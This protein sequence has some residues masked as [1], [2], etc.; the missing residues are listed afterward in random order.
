M[1]KELQSKTTRQR[2]TGWA[3][4]VLCGIGWACRGDNLV[5]VSCHAGK[6]P[7]HGADARQGRVPGLSGGGHAAPR[8]S[9]GPIPRGEGTGPL[10]LSA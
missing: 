10:A 2:L 4:W 6:G 1:L 3:C 7:C 8:R 9:T 5:T